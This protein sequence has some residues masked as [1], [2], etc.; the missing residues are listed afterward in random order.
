M[1]DKPHTG[2]RGLIISN[3]PPPPHDNSI[4]ITIWAHDRHQSIAMTGYLDLRADELSNIVNSTK[5]DV[6]S[7]QGKLA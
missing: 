7:I 3:R 1:H 6:L 4:P 5:C 2:R